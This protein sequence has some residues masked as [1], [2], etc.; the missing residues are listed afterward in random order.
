MRKSERSL[1]ILCAYCLAFT[2]SA[3]L[4]LPAQKQN[5]TVRVTTRLVEVDIV[6]QDKK[7][8]AITDLTRDDFEVT[9]QGRA[10]TI[11]VCSVV[12]NRNALGRAEAL[13]ANT[14]SNLP[15][16]AG[17]SPNFTAVLFDILN[18]PIAD[19]VNAKANVM[20]FLQQIQPPDRVA[21]YGL[22]TSLHVIHDYTGDAEALVRAIDHFRVRSSMEQTASTAAIEDSTWLAENKQEADIIA[23]MD[24]FLNNTNRVISRYYIEQRITTTLRALEAIASHLASLPGRKSL[25]WV[26]AGFPF[27]YG[28]NT[29]RPNQLNEGVK[30]YSETV[31]R[32]ARS[33][34]NANVAIYPVDARAL[35][36]SATISPSSSA[37]LVTSTARQAALVDTQATDEVLASHSTM[38]ELADQTGG[39]ATYNTGDVQGA[40]QRALE[41]SRSTYTLGYYPSDTR[42]DGG[43]RSIKVTV[44]RPGVQLKYR[45]GY[46]AFPDEPMDDAHRQKSL[47]AAATSM[48]DA[49]GIGFSVEASRP[50]P[51]S[52]ALQLVMDVER[53]S[54]KLEPVQNNWAV[55]LDVM[56]AQF[57]AKGDLVKSSGRQVN[58]TLTAADR[59]QM[60]QHGFVLNV[61]VQ[62]KE[63]CDHLRV[64][65]RDVKT[66]ALGS[67][68]VPLS[69]VR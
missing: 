3:R 42:F 55:G 5:A 37:A 23:A 10:Q 53:D 64:I 31:T 26:S 6:A 8:A 34:T 16:R 52:S 17:A 39:R 47:S 13:P 19:Q 51:G 35:L 63:T 18:T 61:P 54:I 29:M 66:G 9:E 68:T 20:R 45:R 40:I 46:F 43:F 4:P 56:L 50:G 2:V 24:A 57:D 15:S 30:N 44:K 58:L 25:V 62:L 41:D 38:Q 12:S 67:V 11:S 28:S 27:S 49:A 65:L 69:A 48:L 33:I 59:E 22:A 32:T 1:A 14:F 36:G 21:V 60:L 7:G